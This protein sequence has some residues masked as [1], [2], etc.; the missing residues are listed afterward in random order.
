MDYK[1]S[2]KEINMKPLIGIF[3]DLEQES[4]KIYLNKDYY[5]AIVEEGGLPVIIPY[6]TVEN[7]LE[8]IKSFHGILFSGGNDID[9]FHIGEDPMPESGKIIPI[10]D[11]I[12]LAVARHCLDRDIPCLGICRG[13]QTMAVAAKGTFYQDI[14]KQR[15]EHAIIKHI[16][17]APRWYPTHEISIKEESTL[18]QIFMKKKIRVNS[19]HHQAVKQVGTNM[20]ISAISQDG[21][22]E[23]MEHKDLGFYIGVQWHPENMADKHQDQ[24][25]LFKAF[26]EFTKSNL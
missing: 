7:V 16:Q 8:L 13:M 5:N 23:A 12:E 2:L 17:Q 15:K 24:K 18:Y 20:L 11:E 25:R 1:S 26:V 21:I 6:T 19:F 9:P 4:G 22:I 14:Y 10:R 3:P